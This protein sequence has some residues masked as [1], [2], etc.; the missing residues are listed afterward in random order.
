[1]Q[2]VYFFSVPSICWPQMMLKPRYLTG[3]LQIC[4]F[5]FDTKY[6]ASI[7]KKMRAFVPSRHQAC[8]VLNDLFQQDTV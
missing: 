6:P 4:A 3:V 8:V 7:N 2:T 5:F 1:M